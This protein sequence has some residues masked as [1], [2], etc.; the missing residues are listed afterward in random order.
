MV[1]ARMGWAGETPRVGAPVQPS[2]K[3]LN[4]LRSSRNDWFAAKRPQTATE[5]PPG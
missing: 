3:Q 5:I 2:A 4:G 1:I